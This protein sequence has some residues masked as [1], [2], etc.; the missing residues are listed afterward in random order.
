[1]QSGLG[2]TIH[3]VGSDG[4]ISSTKT[5]ISNPTLNHGIGFTPDGKT[6]YVSSMTTAWRYSYDAKSQT[7]S[8]QVIVVK[9]MV[10]GGHPTRALIVPPATPNL[11]VIQLG[12]YSNFDMESLNM[13]TARAVVKVFNMSSVPTGGYTYTTEGWF[14]GYGL[15]NDV[16]LLTDGN[17]MCV[18]PLN[19]RIHLIIPLLNR[20]FPGSGV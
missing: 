18:V 6:L 5:L 1:V 20:Q 8:D 17:N 12:S 13:A 11:L 19:I 14:L 16:A 4:C 9:G 3:T 15:R 7:V 10:Q 2:V